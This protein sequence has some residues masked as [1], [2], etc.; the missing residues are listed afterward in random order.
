MKPAFRVPAWLLRGIVFTD[1]TVVLRWLGPFASTV[2]WR[3]L[4][5]AMRV[6]GHDGKTQAVF[7]DD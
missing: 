7:L 4:G 2:V 6:H 3:D 1:G 5:D